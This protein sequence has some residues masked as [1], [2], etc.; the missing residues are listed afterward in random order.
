MEFVKVTRK[1]HTIAS[2]V[3]CWMNRHT[4]VWL[5]QSGL[6]VE[7]TIDKA[8][9]FMCERSFVSEVEDNVLGAVFFA[10]GSRAKAVCA[11]CACE[12]AGRLGVRTDEP[13]PADP[14]RHSEVAVRPVA[15]ARTRSVAVVEPLVI[16]HSIA[17]VILKRSAEKGRVPMCI[18]R[19][20]RSFVAAYESIYIPIYTEASL[21]RVTLLAA[22]VACGAV[23]GKDFE[24]TFKADGRGARQQDKSA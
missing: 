3:V 9:C 5:E 11:R 24:V 2:V 17:Y 7:D 19:D 21:R 4:H 1:K 13:T 20:T 18:L 10:D 16:P 22:S 14:D 8:R 23:A 6:G 15:T 12:V